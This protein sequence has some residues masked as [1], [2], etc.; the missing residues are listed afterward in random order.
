MNLNGK[1][2]SKIEELPNEDDREIAATA[3]DNLVN[4]L[5]DVRDVRNALNTLRNRLNTLKE[6]ATHNIEVLREL[7]V[8]VTEDALNG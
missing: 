8:M 5:E 4:I 1:A 7:G 2:V 6:E 3:Y